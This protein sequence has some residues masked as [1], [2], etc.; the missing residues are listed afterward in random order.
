MTLSFIEMLEKKLQADPPKQKGVRTRERLKIATA[1]VLEQRGYHAMRVSDVSECAGVA[2]GSFYVYFKD[3]TDAAVTV[4]T[5]MLETFFPVQAD[6]AKPA[7]KQDAGKTRLYFPSI[8]EANRRWLSACRA[9]SGLIR[10]ILQLGDEEPE[11]SKL[12][13]RSNRLWYEH[14]AQTLKHD[15]VQSNAQPALLAAYML[16]AMMDELVRKVIVYP[17]P[18]FLKHLAKL[19]AD[20]DALAD[21]ASLIWLRVFHPGEAPPKDLPRAAASL[22]RWMM[23]KADGKG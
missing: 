11:F 18:E 15:G 10:C 7:K 17:D 13:H 23:P 19:D 5:D 16:G 20:D 9:N 12:T 2:E 6:S 8:R 14:I 3:K 22:A 1:R 4:L 21:A